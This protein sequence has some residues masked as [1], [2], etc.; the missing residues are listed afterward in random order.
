VSPMQNTADFQRG[1]LEI[2]TLLPV[3][4]RSRP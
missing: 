2:Y 3:P 4:I 1:H